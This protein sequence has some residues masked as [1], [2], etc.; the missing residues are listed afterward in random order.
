METRCPA[1]C[2]RVI[3]NKNLKEKLD[4]HST[5]IQYDM[6]G[7]KICMGDHKVSLRKIFEQGLK[8]KRIIFI[9]LIS[10]PIF[11][12][13]VVNNNSCTPVNNAKRSINKFNSK[14]QNSKNFSYINHNLMNLNKLTTDIHDYAHFINISSLK[15]LNISQTYPLYY[16]KDV[17]LSVTSSSTLTP[18]SSQEKTLNSECVNSNF[19]SLN[20]WFDSILEFLKLIKHSSPSSSTLHTQDES[21]KLDAASC[22]CITQ[23]KNCTECIL[24]QIDSS[25]LLKSYL[26]K[27]FLESL[28][29]NFFKLK[30]L[31]SFLSESILVLTNELNQKMDNGTHSP[32]STYVEF[33]LANN[34]PL[35]KSRKSLTILNEIHKFLTLNCT[36]TLFKIAVKKHNK[37]SAKN[38]LIPNDLNAN[39]EITCSVNDSSILLSN[40]I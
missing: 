17:N 9:F 40:N 20:K 38:H 37:S 2:D 5:N 25:M 15:H 8:K 19:V 10:K 29:G 16:I 28:G 21:L 35:D 32:T 24:K 7:E 18:P 31:I 27:F 14:Q 6:I 22:M 34:S 12:F 39:K 36:Y 13:F 33:D 3:L 1:W 4:K 30:N 26:I 23:Y 11:L